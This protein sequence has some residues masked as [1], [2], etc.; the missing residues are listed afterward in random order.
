MYTEKLLCYK[1]RTRALVLLGG[2]Q[3]H[4]LKYLGKHSKKLKGM[5]KLPWVPFLYFSR[6]MKNPDSEDYA[7][8]SVKILVKASRW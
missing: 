1:N 5:L 3:S 8:S 7:Y 2:Y 4:H 6:A